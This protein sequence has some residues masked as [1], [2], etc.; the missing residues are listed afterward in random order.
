MADPGIFGEGPLM[1]RS[2]FS[3]NALLP[4]QAHR[5]SPFDPGAKHGYLASADFGNGRAFPGKNGAVAFYGRRIVE[6]KDACED[7]LENR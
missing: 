3:H 7:H 6:M 2:W 4:T 1:A 5:L